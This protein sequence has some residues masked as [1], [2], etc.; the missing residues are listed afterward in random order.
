MRI[1]LLAAACLSSLL[2]GACAGGQEE[3]YGDD[4]VSDQ[5][6][7]DNLKEAGSDLSKLHDVDFNLYF[8]DESSARRFADKLSG[9]PFKVSIEETDDAE[10][11]VVATRKMMLSADDIKTTSDELTGLAN[12]EGGELDGWGASVVY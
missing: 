11:S 5:A 12:A 4:D 7:I 9:Q 6:V 8:P 10:W 1:Q 3:T 2:L